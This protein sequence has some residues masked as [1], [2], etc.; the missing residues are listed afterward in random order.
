MR[1]LLLRPASISWVCT[2]CADGEWDFDNYS[3]VVLGQRRELPV[4]CLAAVNY[5]VWCGTGNYVHV[6]GG[7]SL[8]MEASGWE[9][10]EL[11]CMV[12][13]NGW[14]QF[15]LGTWAVPLVDTLGGTLYGRVQYCVWYRMCDKVH[16]TSMTSELWVVTMF[17]KKARELLECT[18]PHACLLCSTYVCLF[19]SYC[20]L[21]S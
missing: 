18:V 6:V 10:A 19:Y 15:V 21:P 11:G 9:A 3:L 1:T 12:L 8:K 20:R 13:T 7:S 16:L 5:N 4:T 17:C 2:V 14:E